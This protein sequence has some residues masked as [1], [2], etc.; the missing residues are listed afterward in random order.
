MKLFP[1]IALLALSL[2]ATGCQQ[3]GM[4][5]PDVTLS[6]IRITKFSAFETSAEVDLRVTNPNRIPLAITGSMHE[7]SIDG[8]KIG[9]AA[10]NQPFRVN[11]MDSN[12]LTAELNLSHLS[13]ATQ[14]RSIVQARRFDYAIASTIHLADGLFPMNLNNT[15]TFNAAPE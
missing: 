3:I 12:V 5:A 15:G 4:T 1:L 6:D 14:L 2:A 13:M 10:A 11:A 9:T 7:L 8:E